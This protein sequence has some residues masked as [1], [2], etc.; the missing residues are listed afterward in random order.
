M[1]DD[2]TLTDTTPSDTLS[3]Q[4][5]SFRADPGDSELFRQ[6]KSSLKRKERPA[7]LAELFELRASNAK[8]VSE[9]TR[10]WF[11]ASLLRATLGDTE[12]QQQNFRSAL[13]ADPGHE[14]ISNQYFDLLVADKRFAEA[15]DVA[16][17]EISAIEAQGADREADELIHR[18]LSSAVQDA[19]DNA[20][21]LANL[22][23]ATLRDEFG[24]PFARDPG[25]VG[26]GQTAV[27][28]AQGEGLAA[29]Q[30]FRGFRNRGRHNGPRARA[31]ASDRRATA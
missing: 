22:A 30:L 24:Q 31:P 15:A 9:A 3:A 12:R 29:D 27:V 25:L 6:L 28:E 20:E 23:V 16:D 11:D 19:T 7:D 8:S 4:L 10:L 14:K 21:L 18:G 17:A 2:P 26:P 13:T 1:I 5:Q